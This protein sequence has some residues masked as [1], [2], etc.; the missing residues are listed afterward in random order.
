M[1]TSQELP[2]LMHEAELCWVMAKN[3]YVHG[4]GAHG[5]GHAVKLG[6]NWD[7]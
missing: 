7:L 1:E 3:V 4:K 5:W 2:P 6:S